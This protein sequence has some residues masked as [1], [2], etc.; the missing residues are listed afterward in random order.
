MYASHNLCS[1]HSN[2]EVEVII[3]SYASRFFHKLQPEL[4]YSALVVLLKLILSFESTL[5]MYTANQE[6]FL[7]K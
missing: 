3:R 5:H 2:L 4:Q 1:T 7:L 6:R